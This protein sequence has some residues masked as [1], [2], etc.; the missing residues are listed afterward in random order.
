MV[1]QGARVIMACRS[2]DRADAARAR[3]V[4]EL[5]APRPSPSATSAEPSKPA[6]SREDLEGRLVVRVLDTSLL[7]SVRSFV[8][9]AD[10]EKL[11]ERLDLLILNAGVGG[12]VLDITNLC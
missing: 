8:H 4:A 1:S 3:I 9:S 12:T 11:L 10:E 5:I 7:Q 2:R 6:P